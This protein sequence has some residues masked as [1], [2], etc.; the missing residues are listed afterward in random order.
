MVS[1]LK[2]TYGWASSRLARD[3]HVEQ[4]RAEDLEGF[5]D[6]SFL[7]GLIILI[8]RGGRCSLPA[9]PAGAF[10]SE[11]LTRLSAPFCLSATTTSFVR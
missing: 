2:V 8:C 6:D 7:V 11:A 5:E 1:R 10:G 4:L 3:V 9:P